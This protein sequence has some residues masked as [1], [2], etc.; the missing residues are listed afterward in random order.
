MTEHACPTRPADPASVPFMPSH[1]YG[2][3][4]L[5]QV[6]GPGLDSIAARAVNLP[7]LGRYVPQLQARA[8]SGSALLARPAYGIRLDQVLKRGHIWAAGELRARWKVPSDAALVLF[9]FAADRV[10][11]D[12]WNYHQFEAVARGGWDLITAPSYSMWFQRP[13]PLH[14]LAR[15]RSFDAYAAF[16]EYGAP[17]I[18]RVAFIDLRDV[19][20]QAAWC[21]KNEAVTM[22]S[23]DLM[24]RRLHKD[25]IAN[26]ELLATFDLLT[27]KRLN[28]LINGTRSFTRL[29]Y[30]FELLGPR[31]TLS[32]ATM[33]PPPP[34]LADQFEE[35]VAELLPHSEWERRI[36]DR[37][38]EVEAAWNEAARRTTTHSPSTL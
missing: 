28:Y 32:D 9:C 25:W 3:E 6:H 35:A 16:Q 1:G 10:L 5:A 2:V 31:V 38:T 12:F 37:E 34:D 30:L 36:A 22:V 24:T 4:Q 8:P 21:L 26:A 11:E 18:P 15:K 20:L 14:F 23:L 29:R 7:V 17:A 33:A 19:D 27:K 13:R